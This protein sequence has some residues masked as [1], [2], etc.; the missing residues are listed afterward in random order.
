MSRSH[1]KNSIFGI[2]LSESEKNDKKIWHSRFRTNAKQNLKTCNDYENLIDIHYR[3]VSDVW[4]MAKDGRRWMNI[5][6][7]PYMKKYMRK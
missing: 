1:R 2:T 6:K 3:E 7:M 5:N 4:A